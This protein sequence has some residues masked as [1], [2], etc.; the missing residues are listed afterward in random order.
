MKRLLLT[1]TFACMATWAANAMAQLPAG[2]LRLWLKADSLNLA[3]DAQVTQWVDS[4]SHGTVFAPRTTSEPDG[5]L[6]GFAVEEFPHLQTVTLGGKT[7]KTVKFERDGDIFVAGNPAM[8]RSGSTDRLYQTNNRA[9]GSD[10]LAI[11]DGTSVTTFTVF[12]PNVTVPNTLG[13]QAI[14]AKRGNGASLLELGISGGNPNTVGRFN[15]VTYDATTSYVAAVGPGTSNQPAGK[16][17][18]LRQSIAEMGA[19]DL[20]SFAS[21]HTEIQ[22]NPLVD[23]LPVTNGGL[24]VDRNDGINEDPAGLLEPF[25]IGGH[26]QD[27]CGEG[28][29]FSGNIAEIIIYA[30]T[31]SQAD[32]NQVYSY[33]ANKYLPVPEPASA[34]LLIL[35][36]AGL[37]Q[38]R[39]QR[40]TT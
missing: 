27:C 40:R 12:K 14:W 23:L 39:W 20:L 7:F 24:I 36:L 26:A 9:P 5:P 38:V 13:F 18:I 17:H 15:Y 1:T 35:A 34:G 29:T 33:L 3:E 16:W 21:N 2:D 28:E 11:G 25:G 31:L 6:G 37:G 10:P 32:T 19:N 30:G 8:D 4:S 22:S